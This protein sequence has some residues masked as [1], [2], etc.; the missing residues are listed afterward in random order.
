MNF[1]EIIEPIILEC[2]LKFVERSKPIS[3]EEAR[4]R[5]EPSVRRVSKIISILKELRVSERPAKGLEIGAGY[6]AL[7]F[8]L[9]KLFPSIEWFGIEHPQRRYL[10]NPQYLE[11]L[12]RFGIRLV[13]CD[14]TEGTLPFKDESFDVVTFSEVL[15]HLPME[16]I[17]F[18]LS[19]LHR[20][21]QRGGG[22]LGYI[23]EFSVFAQQGL[24]PHG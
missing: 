17:T 13:S 14:L 22:N 20:V 7:I 15:E 18:V 5:I 4:L 23:S 10:R 19:E 21:T 2:E 9:A 16:S 12:E 6:G 8:P 1:Q 24:D 11:M 3:E